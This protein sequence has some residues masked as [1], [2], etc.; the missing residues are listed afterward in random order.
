MVDDVVPFSLIQFFI[1]SL[2]LCAF[3]INCRFHLILNKNNLE[4]LHGNLANIECIPFQCSASC[5]WPFSSNH[6]KLFW[7]PAQTYHEY[8][9]LVNTIPFASSTEMQNRLFPGSWLKS[10]F[11]TTFFPNFESFRL[12]GFTIII[13]LGLRTYSNA[14]NM[15]IKNFNLSKKL[16][17]T[18]YALLVWRIIIMTLAE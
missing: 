3:S 18:G 4:W 9:I 6:S 11:S 2:Q 12:F 14:R 15:K 13:N 17:L 10:I 7:Q 1:Y 16:L 5:L 8:I